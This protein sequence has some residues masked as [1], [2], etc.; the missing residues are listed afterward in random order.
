MRKLLG[1]GRNRGAKGRQ[2]LAIVAA[3]RPG[4]NDRSAA[5]ADLAGQRAGDGFACGGGAAA[6]RRC[7]R[8]A[9]A[10]CHR[11]VGAERSAAW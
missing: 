2:A 11:Q 1:M 10:G 8:Q 9:A 7:M 5:P 6:I 4:V 3:P